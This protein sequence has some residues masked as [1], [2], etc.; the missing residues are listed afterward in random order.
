MLLFLI[1]FVTGIV[2]A[3]EH[4]D[5]PSILWFKT[6]GQ[7]GQD[8]ALAL[9][10]VNDGFIVGGMTESPAIGVDDSW[11][12][13]IDPEGTTIFTRHYN[14]NVLDEARCIIQ[15]DDGTFVMGGATEPYGETF[16]KDAAIIQVDREGN[17]LWNISFGDQMLQETVEDIATRPDGGFIFSGHVEDWRTGSME[18]LLVAINKTGVVE[19]YRKYPRGTGSDAQS[20]LVLDDGYLFAGY[21]DVSQD[22]NYEGWLA[23]SDKNGDIVWEKSFGDIGI[24]AV[25]RIIPAVDGGYLLVGETTVKDQGT[26]DVWVIHTDDS[27]RIIWENHY[28]G[29]ANDKGF[30][31]STPASGGYLITGWTESYGAGKRDA[32]VIRLDKDGTPWWSKTI[33]GPE[34]DLGSSADEL[35]GGDI[36]VAGLTDSYGAGMYDAMVAKLTRGEL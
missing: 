27:G 22:G 30:D 11:I 7:A 15:A 36:I 35:P 19:W 5:A 4:S 12:K 34:N 18:G 3:A 16:P 26:S 17:M 9:L 23:K 8:D 6:Y 32:W 14:T 1:I 10:P 2:S 25:H 33:G 29:P 21:T 24:N 20:V 13:K 31:V 28:G